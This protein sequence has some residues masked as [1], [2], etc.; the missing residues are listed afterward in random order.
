MAVLT[1][2]LWQSHILN[3]DKF[4]ICV[5]RE[6]DRMG[7]N[8]MKWKTNITT[9]TRNQVTLPLVV[10]TYQTRYHFVH[11]L[12]FSFSLSVS[13]ISHFSCFFFFFLWIAVAMYSTI[14]KCSLVNFNDFRF[15]LLEQ[16]PKLICMKIDGR[17]ESIRSHACFVY[18]FFPVWYRRMLYERAENNGDRSNSFAK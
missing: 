4:V 1:I 6:H 18:Q 8:E 17:K 9:T 15:K 12:I 5:Y 16:M 2:C 10:L 13:T 11:A 7:Q 14:W 3:V